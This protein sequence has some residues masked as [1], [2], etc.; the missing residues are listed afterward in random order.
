MTFAPTPQRRVIRRERSFLVAGGDSFWDSFENGREEETIQALEQFVRPES[1]YIEIGSWIGPTVLYAAHLAG[2]VYAFEPDPTAC[3]RL[4]ANLALNPELVAKTTVFNAGLGPRPGKMQLFSNAVGA[5]NSSIYPVV[6]FETG[7]DELLPPSLE[8][9]V[10][11]A[12]KMLADLVDGPEDVI[13]LDAEGAE[14]EILQHVAPLLQ[15]R[16]PTVLAAF[17]PS[18][19]HVSDDEYENTLH[20]FLYGLSA[21]HSFLQHRYVYHYQDGVWTPFKDKRNL[22]RRALSGRFGLTDA[23]V[24]SDREA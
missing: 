19:L 11:D 15:E 23:L 12:R 16:R 24:F 8:A 14:Y 4:Q 2:E 9:P 3:A 18:H 6:H 7:G 17:N 5:S 10:L 1:A 22:L 20:Q 13:R 21:L